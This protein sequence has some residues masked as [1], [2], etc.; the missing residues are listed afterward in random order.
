MELKS[1]T[2]KELIVVNIRH[3]CWAFP[4]HE[5]VEEMLLDNAEHWTVR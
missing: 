2:E 5:V 3:V 1:V 4:Q